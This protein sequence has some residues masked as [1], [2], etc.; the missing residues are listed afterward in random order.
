MRCQMSLGLCSRAA[1][2]TLLLALFILGSPSRSAAQAINPQVF[3]VRFEEKRSKADLVAEVNVLAVACTKSEDAGEGNRKLALDLCLQV[4]KADKGKA[5][6]GELVLVRHE[7]DWSSRPG[8]PAL[9]ARQSTLR[10]FPCVAGAKGQ[11]ALRWDEPR[12]C[13]AAL[14]GWVPELSPG[15]PPIE[16]GKATVARESAPQK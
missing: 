4:V 13:Y 3:K 12:R 15:A 6:P 16:Q 5:K 2:A 10:S 1:L 8:P 11:V 9:Y 14:A 7:I